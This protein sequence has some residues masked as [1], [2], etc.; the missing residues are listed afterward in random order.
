[1]VVDPTT[2]RVLALRRVGIVPAAWQMPQGGLDAGES[3]HDALVRELMEETG[4]G[5]HDYR[6]VGEY[7]E[8]LAYELPVEYRSKKTGRGQVQKWFL[9]EAS[10]TG[11]RVEADLV[12]FDEARWLKL[13]DLLA[14]VPPFRRAV[15]A[16]LIEFAQRKTAE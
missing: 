13:E 16:K 15:Y 10:E 12:E 11:T 6:I 14:G 3:P 4:L 9:L 8:W 2:G 1:M 7:P 5:T